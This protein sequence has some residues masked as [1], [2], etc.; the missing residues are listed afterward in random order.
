MEKK[1]E[2]TER[3]RVRGEIF[4]VFVFASGPKIAAVVLRFSLTFVFKV[5]HNGL[6]RYILYTCPNL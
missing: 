1:Y 2:G 3:K 5:L 6:P 4:L